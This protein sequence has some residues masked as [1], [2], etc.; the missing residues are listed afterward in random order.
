[1]PADHGPM[2]R[3]T[4]L[5]KRYGTGDTAL[6]ALAGVSLAIP[7]GRFVALL[8]PSGSGKSTLLN[9][10]GAVDRPTAG[11]IAIA[12]TERERTQ[13]RDRDPRRNRSDPGGS[14]EYRKP[15]FHRVRT[16][17]ATFFDRG[18]L[19]LTRRFHGVG[20][21]PTGLSTPPAKV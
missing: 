7:T 14:D 6:T 10:L 3:L 16:F 4:D 13:N 17:W 2:I 11:S 21:A 20:T 5:T 8:G 1:M 18:S 15:L 12:C 9:L 19:H